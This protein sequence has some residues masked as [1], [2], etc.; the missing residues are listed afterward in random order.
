MA[1]ALEPTA[2]TATGTALVVVKGAVVDAAFD[3]LGIRFNSVLHGPKARDASA[4]H[5][6]IAAGDRVNLSRPVGGA[7]QGRIS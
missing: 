5:A 1:K 4:Y 7:A 3:R 2:R 6:G